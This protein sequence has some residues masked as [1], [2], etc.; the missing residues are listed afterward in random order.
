[1]RC[2][3]CVHLLLQKAQFSLSRHLKLHKSFSQNHLPVPAA[4]FTHTLEHRVTMTGSTIQKLMLLEALETV[5]DGT[6][7]GI[8]ISSVRGLH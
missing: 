5:K 1:M 4:N 8:N 6:F 7:V 2:T 3:K